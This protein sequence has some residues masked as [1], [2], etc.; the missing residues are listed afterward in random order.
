MMNI[1]T[2][3]GQSAIASWKSKSGAPFPLTNEETGP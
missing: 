1:K 2:A 3:A